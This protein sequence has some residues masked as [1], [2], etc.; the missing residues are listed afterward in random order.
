VFFTT[1]PSKVCC[2]RIARCE[3][4]VVVALRGR[5]S[6]FAHHSSARRARDLPTLATFA[7]SRYP[8]LSLAQ[9]R[10]ESSVGA[11]LSTLAAC[12]II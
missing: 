9:S 2:S 8:G 10:I 5:K 11:Q 12:K 3:S 7:D 4:D 1:T 6:V